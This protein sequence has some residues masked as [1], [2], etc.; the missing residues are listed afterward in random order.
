MAEKKD[1][2]HTHDYG[3]KITPGQEIKIN[4]VITPNGDDIDLSLLVALPKSEL[5]AMREKSIAAEE[6]IFDKLAEASKEWDA[7]AAQTLLFDFAL[8]YAKVPPTKHTENRWEK[9]EHYMT[10]SNMVFKMT[11]YVYED[12]KYDRE[13]KMSVP[14]AW[15]LTWQVYTNSPNRRNGSKIAGQER[16]RFT[17]KASMEKYLTG[18]IE[19]YSHL[20]KEISP[21]IP[22]EYAAHFRVRGQL[23]P[24][25]TVQY[26]KQKQ[27]PPDQSIKKMLERYTEMADK[28]SAASHEKDTPGRST[29]ER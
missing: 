3:N 14:V 18:R 25:Y 29:Y 17:D 9:D 23:L 26:E 8:E 22:P 15:H 28:M 11:Y 7:Q 2:Y 13:L 1:F 19:A 20:F 27:V 24:G 5:E 12:T 16:K 10:K 6:R 21:P 4:R